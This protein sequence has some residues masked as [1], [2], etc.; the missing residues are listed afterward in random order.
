MTRSAWIP[1][2]LALLAP[3]PPARAQAPADRPAAPFETDVPVPA[4][5]LDEIVLEALRA[6]GIAPARSCSDAVFVRRVFLDLTGTLPRPHEALIFLEDRDPG[7]RAALIDELLDRDEFAEYWTLKWCDLLR[8][9]AE[10]PVNLWP[11]G[12]QAYH[13][14]I[15]ESLRANKPVDRFARELLTSSGSNFRVPPVNFYRALQGKD[16]AAFAG[17]AALTFMGV[18]IE[19]WPPE[20]RAQ[21]QAFF[22]R[23]AFKGTAEWKEVIVH[24]NP[25]PA[26]PLDVVFPDG[27]RATSPEGAD[28]RVAFADWLISP[29]N[30]WFARNLANR[31]WSWLMGRGIV[32]EPDDFRP[33]NPPSNPALLDFL[34]RELAASGWDLR[35]LYR[36]ILNSRTYQQSPIPQSGR[37]EAAALFAVYPVRRLE[38]EVLADALR[39]ICRLKESYSSMI[40]EPFTFVPDDQRAVA[41]ADGSTTGP[42]LELFGRPPRDT[43]L[44]SERNNNPS[45]SQRL[46]LLNGSAVQKGLAGSSWLRKHLQEIQGDPRL[47]IRMLYLAVLSREP[48]AAELAAVEGRFAGKPGGFQDAAV[49]LAWALV[50]TKEFQFRH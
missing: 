40:P 50:N 27:T 35:R 26:G 36:L 2:L 11:N 9:K 19:A 34:A 33:D 29:D 41:L 38:A 31:V 44:E 23:L 15:Q 39:R 12:V 18:R 4:G 47:L 7:K 42:F 3:V 13:R 5:P 6:K 32:H 43:G 16:P 24:P 30:A 46:F 8:V 14:W 20:R 10:F 21:L 22:S 28:P 48:T 25:A 49:D 1:L 17:A 45:D 37:P